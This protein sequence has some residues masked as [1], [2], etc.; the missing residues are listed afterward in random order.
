MRVFDYLPD[1]PA[2]SWE[3]P[4]GGYAVV[5]AIEPEV[6]NVDDDWL[7][8]LDVIDEIDWNS[9]D[10]EADN[11]QIRAGLRTYI[12]EADSSRTRQILGPVVE[13]ARSL[14]GPRWWHLKFSPVTTQ[15]QV[16]LFPNIF[17]DPL[18]V[19]L[20]SIE[21]V[22]PDQADD[23]DATCGMDWLADASIESLADPLSELSR[24]TTSVGIV[25]VGQGSMCVLLAEDMGA[26][27]YFDIGGGITTNRRTWPEDLR[28][29]CF[30]RR[31]VIVLSHWDL[32]HWAA[33]R[34]CSGASNAYANQ[35]WIVP[36]NL[37]RDRISHSHSKFLDELAKAG[38]QILVWPDNLPEFAVG[39]IK[40]IKATGRTRNDSG[41]VMTIS[42]AGSI[43]M[44][45]DASPAFVP[46]LELRNL[47]VLVA[48]HHGAWVGELRGPGAIVASFGKRNTYGHPSHH[49]VRSIC[50]AA[51]KA[52]VDRQ[53]LGTP[54]RRTGSILVNL[55][56]QR[57]VPTAGGCG[58]EFCQLAFGQTVSAR[59]ASFTK[60]ARLIRQ[61]SGRGVS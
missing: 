19:K 40:L 2:E 54:V 29:V 61:L 12:L 14:E 17:A 3:P 9:R 6:P 49:T 13:A 25:D 52:T 46:G 7:L 44:T 50:G 53:R 60:V 36:R 26:T 1:G 28:C 38:A 57:S 30:S 23:L 16:Q 22:E 56:A 34:R 51:W 24:N 59:S 39:Q 58:G 32:D 48:P 8:R 42:G 41:L 55:T 37:P 10:R 4:R 18:R 31:Q 45:G 11:T 21:K 33:H 15:P 27:G 47:D 5:D 20:A 43:A 35:T